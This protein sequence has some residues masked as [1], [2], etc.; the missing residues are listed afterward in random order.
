MILLERSFICSTI[1][2]VS[3][4]TLIYVGTNNYFLAMAAFVLSANL[5]YLLSRIEDKL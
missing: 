3:F 4:S 5:F 1:V 2:A